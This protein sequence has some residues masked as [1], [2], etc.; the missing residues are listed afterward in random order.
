MAGSD[1]VW[2][3]YVTAESKLQNAN[4]KILFTFYR[5]KVKL[6]GIFRAYI[7]TNHAFREKYAS[8]NHVLR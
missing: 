5:I 3:K 4:K 1:P 6:L 2:Q 8:M 7:R